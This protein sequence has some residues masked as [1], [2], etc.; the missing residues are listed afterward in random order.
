M[1]KFK[2]LQ[3]F[4]PEG[5]AGGGTAT[6]DPPALGDMK[7][8]GADVAPPLESPGK[9]YK[10]SIEEQKKPALAPAKEDAPPP[11]PAKPDAKKSDDKPADDK[12][13][14]K[15]EPVS[16]LDAAMEAEVNAAAPDAATKPEV[17]T[18]P[19]LAALLTDLPETLPKDKQA[20]NFARARKALAR[21][22]TLISERNAIIQN[23]T[24]KLSTA[25]KEQIDAL[26]KQNEQLQKE[27]AEYKD[28]MVA[29]NIEFEPNH[30][31]KFVEG[32][33]MLVDKAAAKLN[34]FG[35]KGELIVEAMKLP[36][37]RQ[38][39]TAID[40][41]L[42]D[43][44]EGERMRVRE[45]ILQVERLDDERAEIQKDPQTAW[46]KLQETEVRKKQE[47]EQEAQDYKKRIY[48]ETT[49]AMPKELLLL[50]EIAPDVPGAEEHNNNRAK[51]VEGA[52]QTLGAGVTPQE[53]AKKA[54]WA[55]AGPIL[56]KYLI[57]SRKEL[58]EALSRVA[59]Y[60]TAEPGFHGGKPPD[61]PE[62][63]KALEKTPGQVYRESMRS[64]SVG[65]E[66]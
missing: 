19:E 62:S 64:Q 47:R 26:T 33:A 49:R 24:Q 6:I 63:E 55:E 3:F 1:S 38:R 25:G 22:E 12:P 35:G 32:R 15:S 48:D 17:Q 52:W 65:F 8:V 13:A 58:R 27:N 10:K 9:L 43:L 45:H 60:E 31:K 28:S 61:K 53:L 51:I 59:E 44:H 42:A 23:Q 66:G 50:R 29:L 54:F 57:T 56:Q 18:D 36:E 21:A 39:T 5:D 2:S 16:A 34:A 14:A 40:D 11:E 7:A 20:E 37:S 41:A 4:S 46:A 30:R